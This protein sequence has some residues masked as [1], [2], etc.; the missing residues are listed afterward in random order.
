MEMARTKGWE[1][2]WER[3]RGM[4]QTSRCGERGGSYKQ[5]QKVKKSLQRG[6]RARGA[7]GLHLEMES[8][9]N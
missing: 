2:L 6:E 7:L 3:A 4:G 5:L 9:V 1:G 8:P